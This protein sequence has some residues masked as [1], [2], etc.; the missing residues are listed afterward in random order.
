MAKLARVVVVTSLSL[1]ASQLASLLGC[2][3]PPQRK[4][5][6]M[7]PIGT[8]P[9][10]PRVA[11][12]P[13]DGG[14]STAPNSGTNPASAKEAACTMAEID[15]LAESLRGCDVPMPKPAELTP[16]LADKLELSVTTNTPSVQ[17]GGRVDVTLTMKNRTA[18]PLTLYFSGEGKIRFEVEAY[19]A[20]GARRIDIPNGKPP[21]NAFPPGRPTKVARIILLGGGS[22]RVRVPWDATKSRWAPEKVRSWDGKGAARA[23]MGEMII[24]KYQLRVALPLLT[25]EKGDLDTPKVPIDIAK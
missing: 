14:A 20:K 4:P 23:P 10:I 22:A 13:A 5:V 19:D 11:A 1:A 2:S 8:V 7:A 9:D 21:K 3:P 18:D 6:E 25:P 15:S 17:P 12:D 24:G 16:G